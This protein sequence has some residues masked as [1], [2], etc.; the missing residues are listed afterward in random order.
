MAET[1]E[2][3]EKTPDK[4]AV[5]PTETPAAAKTTERPYTDVTPGAII[6]VHQR[7]KE[8]EKERTQIFEGTVIVR[9]GRDPKHSTITVRKLS[10]GVGVEKIFPLGLPTITKIE[11]TKRIHVRRANLGYLRSYGKKVREQK[12]A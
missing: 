8:G 11:V 9:R 2:K 10:H 5:K 6:R 4:P 12:V 7:I 1:K 3:V